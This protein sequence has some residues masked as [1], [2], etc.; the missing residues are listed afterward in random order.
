MPI[1]FS[2]LPRKDANAL[3]DLDYVVMSHV[4]ASHSEL[5][6]MCDESVY[7]AD[8]AAR[9][10]AD[11][12]SARRETPIWVRH[13]DF[14]KRYDLDLVIGGAFVYELKATA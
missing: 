10:N 5:G 3:R 12:I 6:R 1:E 13:D 11:G 9:L 2:G 14:A 7:Q 8:V 4:F